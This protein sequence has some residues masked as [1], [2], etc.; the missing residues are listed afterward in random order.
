MVYFTDGAITLSISM[1]FSLC[2]THDFG[3]FACTFPFFGHALGVHFEIS[4]RIGYLECDRNNVNWNGH[5]VPTG[6][7]C[8]LA[9]WTAIVE[10]PKSTTFQNVE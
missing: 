4:S 6:C 7:Y 8:T 2:R 3:V 1:I 10:V 9:R 5:L